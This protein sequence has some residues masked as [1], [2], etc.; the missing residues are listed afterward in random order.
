MKITP[1]IL[2]I[3][4]YLS[5]SWTQIRALYVQDKALVICLADGATISIPDLD[6]KEIETI[7]AAH[8]AFADHLLSST[9]QEVPFQMHMPHAPSAVPHVEGMS[10]MHFNLEG[11][12]NFQSALQHNPQQAHIPNLP[13][14]ILKKIA[15]IAKIVAPAEIENL[16]KPEP[17]CNCPHCQIARAVHGT[18]EN[19]KVEHPAETSHKIDEEVHAEDLVFQQWEIAQVGDNLYS[20]KNKLDPIEQYRVFL[21]EP[22]GCTCGVAGCEH[23]LAVLKS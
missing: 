18:P 13:E 4:P 14:E 2:S 11:M 8:S 6:P 15:A 20:V 3:P 12:E 10:S 1:K 5:T 19:E 23:I 21:G 17:H 7:F 9:S 16:P 22:V